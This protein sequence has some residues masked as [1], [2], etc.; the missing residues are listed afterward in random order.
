[1]VRLDV[2]IHRNGCTSLQHPWVRSGLAAP[3]SCS[4]T[5]QSKHHVGAFQRLTKTQDISI[6]NGLPTTFPHINLFVV[7]S[8]S[9]PHHTNKP[10]FTMAETAG[11]AA[12]VFQFA[13]LAT[14]SLSTLKDLKKCIPKWHRNLSV[15]LEIEHFK[16]QEW[17]E[18]MGVQEIEP[19]VNGAA[20]W[21]QGSESPAVLITRFEEQLARVLRFDSDRIAALVI[22][23]L[24]MMESALISARD[25]PA[26]A[27]QTPEPVAPGANGRTKSI[28]RLFRSKETSPRPAPARSKPQKPSRITVGPGDKWSTL[29]KKSFLALVD[30]VNATNASLFSLL[31][32]ADRNKICRRVQ[33]SML[34]SPLLQ[35]KA[36]GDALPQEREIQTLAAL[37]D[38][39]KREEGEEGLGDGELGTLRY[40]ASAIPPA[41]VLGVADFDAGL[42]D[43]MRRA[44]RSVAAI[45]GK[46]VLVEWSGYKDQDE[47]GRL[48]RRGN[49]VGLLSGT[50]GLWRKFHTF[51]LKGVIVLDDEEGKR[52]GLVFDVQ[53]GIGASL[54]AT[55]LLG[56][57]G[58][59]SPFPVGQRFGMARG[60][61]AAV[62]RLLSVGWL[63]KALRSDNLVLFDGPNEDKEVIQD[64]K[65][66]SVKQEPKLYLMGWYSQSE[67]SDL[68]TNMARLSSHPELVSK[69]PSLSRIRYQERYDIYSFGLI[70]LQIGLWKPLPD[71]FEECHDSQDELWQKIRGE[72]CDALVHTMG[73]IYWRATKRC[74]HNNFDRETRS[75]ARESEK[76]SK[77]RKIPLSVAFERQ[78]LSEFERCAA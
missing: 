26:P 9:F 14:S 22:E 59:R 62:H 13:A 61:A 11:V 10:R 39:L 64:A 78:V 32:D 66:L 23:D 29:D 18:V 36:I 69:D 1:M 57:L 25:T 38:E 4:L 5:I 44:A 34:R 71:L 77:K 8:H 33:A 20:G 35:A 17:C 19:I 3:V 43:L 45:S 2:I 54:K 68:A 49:L 63:H 53:E 47:L 48:M 67:T 58:S 21:P 41:R 51:C 37:R 70:L 7:L 24:K 72:Y 16:F 73:E 15:K 28:S 40:M 75:S 50:A 46:A 6:T 60:L 42:D 65:V 30:Q 76:Q 55:T 31:G 27:A 74:L 12:T 56:L 52:I